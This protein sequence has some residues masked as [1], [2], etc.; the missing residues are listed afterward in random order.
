VCL[1]LLWALGVPQLPT[2]GLFADRPPAGEQT[3]GLTYFSKD[4]G[5]TGQTSICVQDSPSS[6]AWHDQQSAGGSSDPA[7]VV[8]IRFAIGTA[9]LQTST[10][11]LPVNAIVLE[12][13]LD[14]GAPY[15]AGTKIAIGQPLSPSLFQADGDNAPTR[16]GLYSAP[17]DT[18]IA[19][20]GPVAVSVSGTPGAGAGFCLVRYVVTPQT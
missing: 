6:F 14:V 12:A 8:L 11:V 5:P 20:A 19:T 15:S 16:A 2:F 9:A 18:P 4:I 7:A 17:Q 1:P 10:T 13:M 3:W